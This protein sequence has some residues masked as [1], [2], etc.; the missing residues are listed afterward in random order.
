MHQVTSRRTSD[1]PNGQRVRFAYSIVCIV[2]L[3]YDKRAIPILRRQPTERAAGQTQRQRLEILVD[4]TAKQ[5][6]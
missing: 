5:N 2:L 6:D 4:R 1:V 3:C